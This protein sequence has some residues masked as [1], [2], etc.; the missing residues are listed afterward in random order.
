MADVG[1]G[2]DV[3]LRAAGLEFLGEALIGDVRRGPDDVAFD[4]GILGREFPAVFL[5]LLDR[6]VGG[7]PGELAFLLGGFVEGLLRISGELAQ[8]EARERSCCP[9]RRSR[10]QKT[11]AG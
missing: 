10:Q 1:R 7:V 8:G 5:G 11:A 6:V 2:E 3:D 9:A 4:A